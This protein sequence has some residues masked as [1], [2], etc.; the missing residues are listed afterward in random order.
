MPADLCE[1]HILKLATI[2]AP[3]CVLANQAEPA[4]GYFT[5]AHQSQIDVG[6]HREY[7]QLN[8]FHSGIIRNE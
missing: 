7:C 5:L 6:K 1:N 8:S 4:L 2:A 3:K